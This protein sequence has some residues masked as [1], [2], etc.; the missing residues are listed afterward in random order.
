[1]TAKKMPSETLNLGPHSLDMEKGN[2]TLRW[3]TKMYRWLLNTSSKSQVGSSD[4]FPDSP[5]KHE[6]K[7]QIRKSRK[8]KEDTL[9]SY[10]E[11]VMHFS[12]GGIGDLQVLDAEQDKLSGV[13]AHDDHQTPGARPV[14]SNRARQHGI[15]RGSSGAIDRSIPPEML[16]TI[17]RK[18]TAKEAWEAVK[19]MWMGVDRVRKGN[20]QKLRRDFNNIAFKD[21]KS[22]D[23]FYI[24]ITGLVNNLRLLND[25]IN[26]IK[27]AK[28]EQCRYWKKYVHWERDCRKKKRDKAANLVQAQ[29]E[30]EDKPAPMMAHVASIISPAHDEVAIADGRV[31]LNEE[32]ATVQRGAL[33]S[34]SKLAES[35]L[36]SSKS[37]AVGVIKK[38]QAGVEVKTRRKLRTLRTDQGGEFISV[39]FGLHDMT[40]YEAWHK[41]KPAVHFM[42]TFGCIA[43]VKKTRPHAKKL[44]DKSIKMV[45]V[46]YELG[47]N[48]Y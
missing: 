44:D 32:R 27:A 24:R 30:E 34:S 13:G 29:E 39:T 36:L 12:S 22:V 3:Y 8:V 38:F 26:E 17:G 41:K 1:M 18:P 11:S 42:H 40:P 14:G 47:S 20:A 6:P 25:T 5:R 21:G 10:T 19:I 31:C 43:H 4:G 15:Q 45:F 9:P 48:G 33:A 28:G 46:G 37:E 23:D 7:Q 35:E 2:A 16:S